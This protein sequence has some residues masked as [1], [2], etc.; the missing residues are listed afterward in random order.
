MYIAPNTQGNVFKVYGKGGK[1]QGIES[2]TLTGTS[3]KNATVKAEA[4]IEENLWYAKLTMSA[5]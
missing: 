5:K 1:N 3:D 2:V 4:V